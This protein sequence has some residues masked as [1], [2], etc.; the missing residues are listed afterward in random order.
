MKK[1]EITLAYSAVD[2]ILELDDN[3]RVLFES[4]VQA[5]ENAYAPYSKFLVGTALR[6]DSGVI[7]TGNNQENAAYPSGICAERVAMFAAKSAHPN[8]RITDLLVVTNT[9]GMPVPASPCGACRQVMVEYE[10][11][12]STPIRLLLASTNGRVL[13]VKHAADLLP[14]SFT[15]Q[16]L[17]GVKEP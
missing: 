7:I 1:V 6:L 14:L 16:Q 13:I 3:D 12:Q 17:K 5:R 4:A 9:E 11:Q 10:S 15:A 2:S 8:T